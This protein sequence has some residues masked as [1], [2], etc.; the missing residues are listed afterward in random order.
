MASSAQ[1]RNEAPSC[2]SKITLEKSKSSK[3]EESAYKKKKKVL[4][5]W[6]DDNELSGS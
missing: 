4:D 1:E 3:K 2:P 6:E 5:S